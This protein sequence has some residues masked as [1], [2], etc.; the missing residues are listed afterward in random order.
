MI[1]NSDRH[2]QVFQ[3]LVAAQRRHGGMPV[4]LEE[5]ARTARLPRD[6]THELLDDLTQVHRRVTELAG[7]DEPALGPRFGVAPRL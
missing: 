5:I 4:H 7:G 1:D 3:A 2:E 6:E